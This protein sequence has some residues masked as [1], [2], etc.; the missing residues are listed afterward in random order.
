MSNANRLVESQSSIELK[1]LAC[2]K[3]I[4]YL[5]STSLMYIA[6]YYVHAPEVLFSRP[7]G[8]LSRVLVWNVGNCILCVVV[9]VGFDNF[10]S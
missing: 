1:C 7:I 6:L 8:F 2:T 3:E 9:N 4:L 5:C 10:V